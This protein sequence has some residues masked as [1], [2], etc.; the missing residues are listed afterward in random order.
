MKKS[1]I[2]TGVLILSFLIAEESTA[3]AQSTTEGR[4]GGYSEKASPVASMGAAAANDKEASAQYCPRVT[5]AMS[6][7]EKKC[8]EILDVT[9]TM[10]FFDTPLAEVLELFETQW[11]TQIVLD[12]KALENAGLM[13]EDCVVNANLSRITARTALRLV[14]S[15]M[16]PELTYAVRD[17]IILVTTVQSGK[18]RELAVYDVSALLDENETAEGLAKKLTELL[19]LDKGNDANIERLT[20]GTYKNKLIAHGPEWSQFQLAKLL[21]SLKSE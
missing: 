1:M 21:L 2:V 13:A 15:Q 17:G 20:L 7:R 9:A 18:D 5:S 11:D 4:S 16:D 12:I 8:R 3:W 14:L 6:T 10:E 19:Q